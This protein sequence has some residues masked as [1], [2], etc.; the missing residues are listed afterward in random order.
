MPRRGFLFDIEGRDRLTPVATKAGASLARM[1]ALGLQAFNILSAAA[2]A[3]T[4]KITLLGFAVAKTV[5]V[6][7]EQ[8][9]AGL[10]NAQ[11]LEEQARAAGLVSE[12]YATLS[13]L[14][15]RTGLSISELREDVLV[16]N[17]AL[18]ELTEE[19]RGVLEAIERTTAAT[20]GYAEELNRNAELRLQD[21]ERINAKFAETFGGL[22]V[23]YDNAKTDILDFFADILAGSDDAS[24]RLSEHYQE[25]GADV[26][27]LTSRFGLTEDE[28][29]V[30]NRQLRK[31]GIDELPEVTDKTK[32]LLEQYNSLTPG[33]QEATRVLEALRKELARQHIEIEVDIDAW[34]RRA[35]AWR[36]AREEAERLFQATLSPSDSDAGPV[37]NAGISPRSVPA[38][39]EA[40]ANGF[41][42][43]Y[44][45]WIAQG[46]PQGGPDYVPSLGGASTRGRGTGQTRSL[47]E[48]RDLLL[49]DASVVQQIAEAGDLGVSALSL[50][51]YFTPNLLGQFN[52]DEFAL[53]ISLVERLV[54]QGEGNRTLI[55]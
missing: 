46:M 44:D 19:E 37:G 13:F 32:G 4:L 16:Y 49:Q 36:E 42:G 9:Q 27:T 47:T 26:D 17:S 6:I 15:R 8:V 38:L 29:R 52:N 40:Q 53:L 50:Q 12:E 33:T 31:M 28:A 5:G 25:L 54:E 48:V 41:I 21:T 55:R 18:A 20:A 10:E 23:R 2:G 14:A 30:L 24:E 45:A 1:G 11:Q 34:E 39:R 22:K 3:L 7:R 43:D 51:Q 35:G